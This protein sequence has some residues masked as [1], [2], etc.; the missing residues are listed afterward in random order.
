M[1]YISS[2]KG[3][4]YG[5][6]DTNDG[7]EEFYSTKELAKLYESNKN[8]VIYG[9]SYYNHDMEC[10]VLEL[11]KV[12][13]VGELK[14][15]IK[16]WREVHNQ[17]S[18]Y[19]VRDYLAEA[20]VGTVIYVDYVTETSSGTLMSGRTKL[21]KTGVDTWKYDDSSSSFDGVV[22]DTNRAC[23]FLEVA[24]VYSRVKKIGIERL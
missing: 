2:Q 12:L 22:Y 3:D 16:K 19:P 4:K 23:G 17:W 21:H 5:V 1:F 14:G 24:T 18:G 20:V 13:S 10:T 7:V 9:T 11:G 6:T 8:L 15:R